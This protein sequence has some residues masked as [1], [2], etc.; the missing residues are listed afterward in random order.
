MGARAHSLSPNKGVA[1]TVRRAAA[2]GLAAGCCAAEQRGCGL[3][4]EEAGR[5]VVVRVL[6]AAVV[7]WVAWWLWCAVVECTRAVRGL[8]QIRVAGHGSA[9]AEAS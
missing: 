8:L 1:K 9:P 5:G 7:C 6:G 4:L 3:V 2:W